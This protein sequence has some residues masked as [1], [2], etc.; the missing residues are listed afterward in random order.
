MFYTLFK[1]DKKKLFTVTRPTLN[2][3]A[4]P[5]VYIGKY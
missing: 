1:A 5:K 2:F 4:D 3:T